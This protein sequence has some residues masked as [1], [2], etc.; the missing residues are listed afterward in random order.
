M[1]KVNPGLDVFFDV[2]TLRAG[3]NLENRLNKIIPENDVFYLFWSQS[4]NV[5]NGSR[6]VEKKWKC[7]LNTQGADFID[8]VPL[9]SPEIVPPPPELSNKH[10]ND[11]VLACLRSP[12]PVIRTLED[13]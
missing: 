1:Q 9:V 12:I 10:F 7:A 5:P 3:E 2:L 4:A 11:W 8:P 13:H 6:K